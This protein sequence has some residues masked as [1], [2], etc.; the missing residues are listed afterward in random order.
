MRL[1]P[2]MALAVSLPI[3]VNTAHAEDLSQYAISFVPPDS[4]AECVVNITSEAP[5]RY[6]PETKT[7]ENVSVL[8]LN[9]IDTTTVIPWPRGMTAT[10]ALRAWRYSP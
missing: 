4:Y 2:N 3:L 8:I 9:E 6:R 10:E 1:I 7:G 5:T